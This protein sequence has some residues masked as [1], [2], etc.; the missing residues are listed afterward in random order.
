MQY[1]IV[2]NWKMSP[3]SFV[4]AKALMTQYNKLLRPAKKGR[5]LSLPRVVVCPP[6]LYY[7]FVDEK[8]TSVIH[9]GAQ[10]IFWKSKG[11]F[12]GKISAPMVQEFGAGYVIVGH[13]ELR[14]LGDTD[15][16]VVLKIREALKHKLTPIVCVGYRDW[17]RE[18]KALLTHFS[19]DEMDR[20]IIA[21]E[22]KEAVGTLTALSA[23]EVGKV[24]YDIKKMI[25]RRFR[26]KRFLGI[27]GIG[28]QKEF[29]PKTPIL[30]GGN[31][32][33]AN[34][35]EY[36]EISGVNGFMLGRE[37]LNPQGV[38]TIYQTMEG[39]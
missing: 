15:E 30:Y 32:T 20:I 39:G 16:L 3:S 34:H 5:G 36:I 28:T 14:A 38:K 19:A 9:L 1:Y 29:I 26:K 6:F 24:V 25:Y 35:K 12:T 10:D 11:R 27:V 23:E 13:T 18:S 21:Y 8:R 7:Q 33:A 17:K 4:K 22:P 37:S 31:V 2:C